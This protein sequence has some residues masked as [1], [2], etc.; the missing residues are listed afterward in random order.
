MR[1]EGDGRVADRHGPRVARAIRRR[2]WRSA[3]I[4]AVAALA[5]AACGDPGDGGAA[6]VPAGSAS[7]GGPPPVA[8]PTGPAGEP[9]TLRFVETRRLLDLDADAQAAVVHRC[10]PGNNGRPAPPDGDGRLLVAVDGPLVLVQNSQGLAA[11]LV[12]LVSRDGPPDFSWSDKPMLQWWTSD[13]TPDFSLP[14]QTP[15]DVFNTST[16]EDG[17]V[18]W[19]RPTWFWQAFGR[20]SPQVKELFA[21][22]PNGEAINIPIGATGAFALYWNRAIDPS[23]QTQTRP[24]LSL[25]AR[26]GTGQMLH[27]VTLS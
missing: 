5:L 20:V 15:I 8:L 16:T 17:V 23:E 18:D 4:V 11:C 10:V 6:T 24:P 27:S 1:I 22:I 21:F 2:R 26:D 12:E 7:P 13:R 14:P 9:V 19:E 25:F 3:G